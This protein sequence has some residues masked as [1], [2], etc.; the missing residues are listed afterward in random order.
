MLTHNRVDFELLHLEYMT[1][2]WEHSGIIV[3]P[4]KNAYEIVQRVAILLNTLTADE[5]AN[6]L[7]YV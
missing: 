1:E 2:G 6:Q 5:I 3:T 4:Q 7:L